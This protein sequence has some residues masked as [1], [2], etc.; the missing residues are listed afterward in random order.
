M[1][2]KIYSTEY[3]SSSVYSSNSDLNDSNNKKPNDAFV[4]NYPRGIIN[5]NYP[6]FQH[7]A[8]TLTEH[9]VSTHR[10]SHSHD[11]LDTLDSFDLDY[12]MELNYDEEDSAF[13]K[14]DDIVVECNNNNNNSNELE[15]EEQEKVTTKQYLPDKSYF[16]ALLELEDL[17]CDLETYLKKY[18]TTAD[19]KLEAME[20]EYETYD[21]HL[22]DCCSDEMSEKSCEGLATP[23]I[24][25]KSK[26]PSSCTS[27]SK[28]IHTTQSW[29]NVS[30][31]CLITLTS[32]YILKYQKLFVNSILVGIVL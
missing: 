9:F 18:E 5:P 16:D 29:E 1:K 4:L 23:D 25:I 19:V 3:L 20:K 2:F 12:D 21:S 8:H 10:R 24:L 11:S 32:L 6:G 30:R 17:S 27:T 22:S 13:Q 15:A 31:H 26:E 14:D 7:L 28:A